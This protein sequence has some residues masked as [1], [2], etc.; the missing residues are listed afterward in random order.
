MTTFTEARHPGEHI[1]SEANG[2]LSREQVTLASGN[3]LAA[4]TVLG[5]ITA[6]GKYAVFD[7]DASD[8]TE[9]AAGVLYEAVDASGGDEDAVVHVRQCEVA[10]AALTWPG[11]I[12][13]PEQIAAEA[14]LA[15]L[16]II[17]RT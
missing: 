5:I 9:E 17:V 8:G 16:G 7:Q 13:G 2:A 1:L 10:G 12:T 15:A 14:E 3:N 4:G 11:D 6:S